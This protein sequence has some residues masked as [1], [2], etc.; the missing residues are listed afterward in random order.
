[1]KKF[2]TVFLAVFAALLLSPTANAL[3]ITLHAERA[4]EALWAPSSYAEYT[5]LAVGDNEV[6]LTESYGTY[7]LYVKPAEGF[8][9][10]AINSMAPDEYANLI[11]NYPMEANTYY[12]YSDSEG[13]S[14]EVLTTNLAEVR[15]SK[16]TVAITGDVSKVRARRY[17]VDQNI[18][19]TEAETVL[20]FDPQ[21]ELP[22]RFYASD[23]PFYS[24]KLDGADVAEV[25]EKVYDVTPTDGQRLEIVPEWPADLKPTIRINVPEEASGVV[26]ELWTGSSWNRTQLDFKVNEDFEV[27]GGQYLNLELNNKDYTINTIAIN[28]ESVYASSSKQFF[29]GSENVTID[30]DAAVKQR[31]WFTIN[32]DKDDVAQYDVSGW[33]AYYE[34]LKAGDNQIKPA[35]D[36]WGYGYSSVYVKAV[37]GYKITRLYCEEAGDEVTVPSDP[38]TAITLRP[39]DAWQGRVYKM[40]VVNL[41]DLRA[42]KVTVT[43]NDDPSKVTTRTRGGQEIDFSAAVAGEPFEVK[44]DPETESEFVFGGRNMPLKEVKHNG[45]VVA[46]ETRNSKTRV[47]TVA[48][49]DNI[50]ITANYEDVEVPVTITIPEN[51][52]NVVKQVK[53]GDSEYPYDEVTFTPGEPLMV[54]AGSYVALRLDGDNYKVNHINVDGEKY[55][56]N[57]TFFVG[58]EAVDVDIDAAPYAML[59]FTLNV[60]DPSH[61]IV[62]VGEYG[63]ETIALTGTT[64]ALQVSEKIAKIKIAAADD[65]FISA[66]TDANGEPLT[67]SSYYD[68]VYDITEGMVINVESGQIVNDSEWVLWIE[69]IANIKTGL[70]EWGYAYESCWQDERTR[71]QHNITATGYEIVPFCKSLKPGYIIT[72]Y[73]ESMD[74]KLYW[75]DDEIIMDYSYFYKMFYP[76][77]GDVIRLYAAEPSKYGVTF[78]VSGDDATALAEGVKVTTDLI[79]DRKEWKDGLTLFQGTQVDLALPDGFSNLKVQLDGADLAAGE[80]GKYS[81]VAD[82]DCT[83]TISSS[84]SVI[85]IEGDNEAED[86]A[87]YNLLGVKVLDKATKAELDKLA[88]GVYVVNGKKQV[89]R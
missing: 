42:A 41:D 58:E 46:G 66:I 67:S 50:E 69:D 55:E 19:F 85:E 54:K 8:R 44:F 72:I 5:P 18:D 63:S 77:N 36:S 76:S 12:L 7:Y 28:G 61:I 26:K 20:A 83:V 38:S 3:K 79:N 49:G 2:Y 13:R 71:T 48:D 30:I 16:V 1:M 37:T 87:V 65:C 62:T 31:L 35:E 11:V 33:G 86:G 64:N 32:V 75:N 82:K 23:V 29:V 84:S 17:S 22:L 57:Y 4:G 43:V 25:S 89:I 24:I 34:N 52:P 27:N 47:F 14:Y 15:T 59:N 60:T 10:D 78:N 56:L 39:T 68:K 40:D 53:V 9:L 45:E 80:D 81:F 73:P 6:E 51:T 70:N 74:S 88:P 21:K